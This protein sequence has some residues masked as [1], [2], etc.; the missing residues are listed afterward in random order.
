VVRVLVRH[1]HACV[2]RQN[3]ENGLCRECA[4]SQGREEDL[5]EASRKL[6]VLA[7]T[8]AGTN[9]KTDAEALKERLANSVKGNDLMVA[10]DR[11][12]LSTL[13]FSVHGKDSTGGS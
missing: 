10:R 4:E 11:I 9:A 7:G 6:Q 3:D 12:E 1:G 13:R 8:I 5:A 2:R